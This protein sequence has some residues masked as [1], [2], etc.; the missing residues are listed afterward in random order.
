MQELK[1]TQPDD[2]HVHLRDGQMLKYV[3]HDTAKQFARAA[4][5]RSSRG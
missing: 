3:V 5:Q 4:L 1:F 2:F